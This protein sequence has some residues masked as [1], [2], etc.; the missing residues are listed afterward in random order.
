M[1]GGGGGENKGAAGVNTNVL[2]MAATP[3][4]GGAGQPSNETFGGGG[5]YFE[6]TLLHF[7]TG[8]DGHSKL[9]SPRSQM[10]DNI[11]SIL[12]HKS[13]K[14]KKEYLQ[15]YAFN[16]RD[17]SGCKSFLNTMNKL[18]Q[19]KMPPTPLMGISPSSLNFTLRNPLPSQH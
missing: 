8:V 18:I 2:I 12:S 19:S 1:G 17:S 15:R 4:G 3:L 6:N 9:L 14:N 5:G 11:V 13:I 10:L 7:N 16:K